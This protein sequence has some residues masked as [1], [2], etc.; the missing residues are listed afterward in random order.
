MANLP[1]LRTHCDV[2]Y[3][4]PAGTPRTLPINCAKS[5]SA[6]WP[7][8]YLFVK[9]LGTASPST[10]D[11]IERAPASF[12]VEGETFEG[13][14]SSGQVVLRGVF[15]YIATDPINVSITCEL[16]MDGS[17][18]IWNPN[19]ESEA[20]LDLP[21]GDTVQSFFKVNAD[22]TSQTVTL[23]ATVCPKILWVIAKVQPAGGLL[24]EIPACSGSITV[25]AI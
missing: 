2:E 23:P 12:T 24:A 10:T 25:T 3:T 17:Q 11:G 6:T 19:Y 8:K 21:N 20:L 1:I 22:Y 4:T 14:S 18:S 9:T 13:S 16:N 7:W 15:A 5:D